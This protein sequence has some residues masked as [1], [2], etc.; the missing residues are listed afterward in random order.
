MVRFSQ[1]LLP[2]AFG[3]RSARRHKY[4]VPIE[5]DDEAEY[6]KFEQRIDLLE[7]AN[8]RNKLFFEFGKYAVS[9]LLMM[10]VFVVNQCSD[11]AANIKANAIEIKS[12]MEKVAD[13]DKR[14]AEIR[15][16]Q[17]KNEELIHNNTNKL[18]GV[19]GSLQDLDKRATVNRETE[20]KDVGILKELGV[21]SDNS[22]QRQ[23]DTLGF[24][25]QMVVSPDKAIKESL[26]P[27]K[28]PTPK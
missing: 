6:Q 24:Q 1:H 5:D 12:L 2:P 16:E 14:A 4:D 19:T 18:E 11:N 8:L 25:I 23:I 9:A 10:L 15:L 20:A 7:K 27:K 13:I 21:Q 26:K 22:L 17:L 28:Q 3:L